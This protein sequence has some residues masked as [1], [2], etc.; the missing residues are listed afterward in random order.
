MEFLC[1]IGARSQLPDK[2]TVKRCQ[3]SEAYDQDQAAAFHD[4][5]GCIPAKSWPFCETTSRN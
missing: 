1:L 2:F 4:C 5:V 3:L